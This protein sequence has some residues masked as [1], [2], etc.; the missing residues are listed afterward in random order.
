MKTLI[1]LV[2][3][4]LLTSLSLASPDE[5]TGRVTHIVDGD[6]ID[7][8]IQDH[9]SLVN[10]DL[11]RVRF[12]D[13]D[14]PEMSTAEGPAA[15]AYTTKWLEGN[16][17]QLDIDNLKRM[18]NY[19]RYVAVVY[20]VNTDGSLKNFNRALVD[21]GQACI[22]DFTDNEF[23]P[24]D[25]WDGIIPS[26][27][28]IKSDSSA[29]TH[30]SGFTKLGGASA[31]GMDIFNSPPSQEKDSYGS[32]YPATGHTYSGYDTGSS[33][34]GSTENSYA[35]SSN[36]PFVGSAKSDKYHYP[37]CSAAKRI[38]SSNLVTFSSS[39]DARASGYSPCGICHP[40]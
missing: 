9:G 18:D 25:W 7:V 1:A 36:G 13:I 32:V 22:W 3:L 27:A 14:T 33:Y 31:T 35:S 16:Q 12:A 4:L 10:G 11:I 19:G 28:C 30:S 34:S 40:P 38:K 15:N 20:L 8:S 29:T 37:S 21:A 5:A 23:S 24:T 39:A 17:V 26:S 2:L 6:T